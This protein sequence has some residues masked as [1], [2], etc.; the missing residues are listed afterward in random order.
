MLVV[1]VDLLTGVLVGVACTAARLLYTFARIDIDTEEVPSEGRTYLNL[2]GAATFLALP[3]L[4]EVLDRVSPATELH[5]SLKELTYVDHACLEQFINWEKQHQAT[6]G[7]LFIDW[8]DLT[9]TFRD[10]GKRLQ[11]DA[12]SS[13]D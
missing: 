8:D 5:V 1:G 2:R 10:E 4:T 13:T 9:A 12:S 11:G 3:R 6:G 7:K